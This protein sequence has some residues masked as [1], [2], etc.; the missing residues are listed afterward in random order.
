[1][2]RGQSK[3][4]HFVVAFFALAVGCLAVGIPLALHIGQELEFERADVIAGTR[5]SYTIAR[6]VALIGTIGAVVAGGQL[7]VAVPRNKALS[8]P[9]VRQMLKRGLADLVINRGVLRMGEEIS[10]SIDSQPVHPSPAVA[11]LTSGMFRGL[12]L[13]RST[14]VLTLPGGGRERFSKVSA[15]F[16]RVGR[17]ASRG[18]G[19]AVW[20]GQ[21][22]KFALRSDGCPT[23]AGV[24]FVIAAG[25]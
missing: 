8:G 16:A 4:R 23:A 25:G 18:T 24:P 6:P 19:H 15:D 1:M 22:I 11:A 2:L 3:S 17:S 14:V 9:Q 21:K 7:T 10:P 13:V 5:N 12:K 20:R